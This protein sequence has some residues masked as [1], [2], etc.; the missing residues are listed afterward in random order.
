[1]AEANFFTCFWANPTHWR[2][3][4]SGQKAWKKPWSEITLFWQR[5]CLRRGTEWEKTFLQTS[6][7]SK[8]WG[9]QETAHLITALPLFFPPNAVFFVCCSCSWNGHNIVYSKSEFPHSQQRKRFKDNPFRNVNKRLVQHKIKGCKSTFSLR[10]IQ[11]LNFTLCHKLNCKHSVFMQHLHLGLCL[12][13]STES[14]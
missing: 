13:R 9:Q 14:W 1:M 2:V 6:A 12:W 7:I 5:L 10:L 8:T 3:I 11:Q 4:I